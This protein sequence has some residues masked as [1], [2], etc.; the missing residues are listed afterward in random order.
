MTALIISTGLL[1]IAAVVFIVATIADAFIRVF[2][3]KDFAADSLALNL[4]CECRA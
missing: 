4:N 3:K 2:G 1:A